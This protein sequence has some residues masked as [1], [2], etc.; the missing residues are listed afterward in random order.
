ME[1]LHFVDASLDESIEDDEIE[2]EVKAIGMNATDLTTSSGNTDHNGFGCECSGIITK[3]GSRVANFE[4]SDRIAGISVTRGVYSSRT[5]INSSPAF[6]INHN[7]S[8][9]VGASISIAFCSA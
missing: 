5:R 6:N 2:I 3:K 7:L 9:E 8:F 1:T 4:M